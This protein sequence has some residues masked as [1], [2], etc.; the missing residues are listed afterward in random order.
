MEP[1]V[2]MSGITKRFARVVANQSVDFSVQ[3]GEIHALLGEN[4]AGKTT[5]MNILYGLYS[6]D[7]GCISCKGK[8]VSIKSPLDAVAAGINMVHQHFMLV[9]PLTVAE[10]VV[11]GREP[12]R[13]G[14]FDFSRSVAMVKQIS[15]SYGLAVNPRARVRD[16]SVGEK[17]RVEILKALLRDAEVLILDEPTAVLTPQET[18]DLFHTMRF[19]KS[20]G[21]TC[22]FITHKLNETMTISDRVTVLRKGKLVGTV[23]TSETSPKE[24]ARMMVGREVMLAVQK[25]EAPNTAPI[26]EVEDLWANDLT[27]SDKL[28]G[29]CLQVGGGEIVGIAGVEGNGQSA[30][31]D[32]LIG[33]V[34]PSQGRIL[35]GDKD[36]TL[37]NVKGR[38]DVGLAC[39]PEDAQTQGLVL[40][41]TL[42]ENFVL[43]AQDHPAF[44]HRGI[45]KEKAITRYGEKLISL[46]GVTP[47]C[48][49]LRA[50]QLSGGN[51]QKVILGRE[52]SSSGLQVLIASQP[53]RGLDVGAVEFVYDNLLE[54][55]RKG[56]GILLISADLDELMSLSDRIAVIYE[57]RVVEER[58]TEAYT[59]EE[60]GLYMGGAAGSHK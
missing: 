45:L 51:Q 56:I 39:L 15:E 24:L 43:G 22:I 9:P 42:N 11:L 50:K 58:R 44:A 53:T 2:S 18:E 4:G 6:A 48:G 1:V 21:K 55:R 26:L 38:M 7:E 57:G 29:A 8:P 17:Q 36:V 23:K 30:L 54:L 12:T 37:Q 31:V 60:L 5:L 16:I 32:A 35:V 47:P 19:M 13:C 52:L 14:L 10:N 41:F 33:L 28:R 46:F 27:G 34:K 20:R 49:D 25:D 59:V 3:E 40:E